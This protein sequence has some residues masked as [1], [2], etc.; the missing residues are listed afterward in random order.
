LG[1]KPTT[2]F[3]DLVKEMVK[4]DLAEVDSGHIERD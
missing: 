4:H 3:Y 2:L 1:W